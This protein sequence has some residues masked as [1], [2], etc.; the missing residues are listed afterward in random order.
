MA[1]KIRTIRLNERDDEWIMDTATEEVKPMYCGV[2]LSYEDCKILREEFKTHSFRRDDPQ[3]E[4]AY[5]IMKIVFD[6]GYEE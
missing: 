1:R 5:E 2:H 4:K 6:L 3:G